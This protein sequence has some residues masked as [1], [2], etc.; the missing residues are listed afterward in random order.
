[1]QVVRALPGNLVSGV[2]KQAKLSLT[3]QLQ[4]FPASLCRIGLLDALPYIVHTGRLTSNT[5]CAMEAPAVLWKRLHTVP[6]VT[7]LDLWCSLPDELHSASLTYSISK[8]TSIRRLDLEDCRISDDLCRNLASGLVGLPM[9]QE[10]DLR[11]NIMRDVSFW[12]LT[13]CLSSLV[14]LE[15]LSASGTMLEETFGNFVEVLGDSN[16]LL[17]YLNLDDICMDSGYAVVLR[18]QAPKLSQLQRLSLADNPLGNQGLNALAP[19]L[20]SFPLLQGL[21]CS[22]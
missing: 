4:L 21:G 7:A 13:S 8:V 14:R 5:V 3:Q 6:E 11:K 1:M 20:A 10:L 9:L 17:W 12:C 15:K 18:E 19:A 2:L 16:T 22:V